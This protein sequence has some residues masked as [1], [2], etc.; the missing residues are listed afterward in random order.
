VKI[1]NF[2][3][4]LED[5]A[6]TPSSQSLGSGVS[7]RWFAP[8]VFIGQGVLSLASDIYA[9]GMT[10]LEVFHGVPQTTPSLISGLAVHPR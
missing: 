6:V 3:Q 1:N 2:L 5:V 10:A 9:Y 4:I 8:E 7:H